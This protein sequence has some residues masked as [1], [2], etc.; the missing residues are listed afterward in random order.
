MGALLGA[1]AEL[2]VGLLARAD[3]RLHQRLAREELGL[4]GEVQG[5][6]GVARQ[7]AARLVEQ[8]PRLGRLGGSAEDVQPVRLLDRLAGGQQGV[9]RVA[10][11]AEVADRRAQPAG[12]A[13]GARLGGRAHAALQE[14]ERAGQDLGVG[15]LALASLQQ[16]LRAPEPRPRG[17][18]AGVRPDPR[19][20][21]RGGRH[22]Q[23]AR[24]P[25]QRLARRLEP[26]PGPAVWPAEQVLGVARQLLERPLEVPGAA[27][28]EDLLAEPAA[29]GVELLLEHVQLHQ[30]LAPVGVGIVLGAGS[31]RAPGHVLDRR[32]DRVEAPGHGLGHRLAFAPGEPVH[33]L[34]P[35]PQ[36]LDEAVHALALAAELEQAAGDLQEGA[37]D[38]EQAR[39]QARHP[40]PLR[41]WPLEQLDPR[42]GPEQRGLEVLPRLGPELALQVAQRVARVTELLAHRAEV[43]PRLAAAVRQPVH[44]ADELGRALELALRLIAR[45]LVD[46]ARDAVGEVVR[47]RAQR[48][49]VLLGGGQPSRARAEPALEL[50]APARQLEAPRHPLLEELRGA[51]RILHALAGADRVAR[52]EERRL[53]RLLH[54]VGP[55]VVERRGRLARLQH[56]LERGLGRLERQR[57]L[58]EQHLAALRPARQPLEP[59]RAL[60]DLGHRQVA[61]R[62]GLQD[63]R[64]LLEGTGAVPHVLRAADL[65]AGQRLLERAPR[66]LE[67]VELSAGA[68][69]VLGGH[70]APAARGRRSVGQERRRDPRGARLLRPQVELAQREQLTLQA[71]RLAL[72]RLAQR[73]EQERGARASEVQAAAPQQQAERGEAQPEQQHEQRPA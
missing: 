49:E 36:L 73:V 59:L 68:G 20:A 18:Q 29:H 58:L 71:G 27:P 41:Q 30:Q 44:V 72:G 51:L 14:R 67:L 10:A 47:P 48:L 13:R 22:D 11:H 24:S 9:L 69:E 52:G 50:V 63:R 28:H 34:G 3:L 40:L 66:A 1:R 62:H 35:R 45:P 38:Q 26:A 42:R 64:R 4:L 31:R 55:V 61:P 23:L 16:H 54:E 6:V 39:G 37:P 8:A 25:D 5:A 33:R 7:Q 15:R 57:R 70:P 19:Q 53:Q 65:R 56:P 32:S 46:R 12:V 43:G 21:G 17:L 60:A 2:G